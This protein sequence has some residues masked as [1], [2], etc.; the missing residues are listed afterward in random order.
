MLSGSGRGSVL[1]HFQR[2]KMARRSAS[3]STLY[4]QAITVA[5]VVPT[6]TEIATAV[7]AAYTA[8]SATPIA[9]DI[10][11]LTV[12]SVCKLRATVSLTG[13][14]SGVFVVS[15]TVSSV[16]YYAQVVQTGLY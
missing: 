10:I 2:P 9:G 1:T 5:G 3:T 15:F 8:A 6:N 16:T 4:T 12:S 14:A 7:V 11:N 13:T